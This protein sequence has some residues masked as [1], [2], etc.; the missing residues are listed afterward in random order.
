MV[1]VGNATPVERNPEQLNEGRGER[2]Q[3]LV[4]KADGTQVHPRRWR[5]GIE[6]ALRG[7]IVLQE[8]YA[9]VFKWLAIGAAR[10][11]K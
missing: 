5:R 1:R 4:N 7:P 3:V 9:G 11:C 8:V 10:K 2:R 6:K